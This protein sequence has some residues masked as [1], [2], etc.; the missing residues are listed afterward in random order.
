MDIYG[1]AWKNMVCEDISSLST[2]LPTLFSTEN[3]RQ[4]STKSYGKLK[5]FFE[6]F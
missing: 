5:F 3:S 2:Y 1:I 4:V 6:Y